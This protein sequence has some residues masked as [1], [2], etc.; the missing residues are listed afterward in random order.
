[1]VK[2]GDKIPS[3]SFKFIDA[4]G[5]QEI[6]TEDLTSGKKVIIFAVPGAFTPTC[7][8][9]H[10]PGFITKAGE[11]KAKGVDTIACVAVNDPFVM[12]AWAKDLGAGKELLFVADGNGTWTKAMDLTFDG[13]DYGLGTRSQ[14][15]AM[16]VEDGVIKKLEVE[17]GEGLTCSGADNI[18]TLL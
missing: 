8:K 17:P 16:V 5:I 4:S 15:Y 9:S 18:L 12:D 13:S 14:R 7:S 11:L 2:V 3:G 1:M 6:T 10:A